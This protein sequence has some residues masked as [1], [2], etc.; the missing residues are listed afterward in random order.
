[1]SVWSCR[2][3]R[4][5]AGSCRTSTPARS[6]PRC[7]PPALAQLA[8]RP[9][10]EGVPAREQRRVL[11]LDGK[12]VRGAHIPAEDA[13]GDTGSDAGAYRQPHLVSVLEQTAQVALG[14]VQVGTKSSEVAAFTTL[15]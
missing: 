14:Q 4:P 2:T 9:P 13:G 1:M 6:R 15:A 5:S 3:S 12:S 11:A 10:P 8:E 7:V